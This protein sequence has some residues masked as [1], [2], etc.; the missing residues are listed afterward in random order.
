MAPPRDIHETPHE[1]PPLCQ[2]DHPLAAAIN[3]L[4]RKLNRALREL[5]GDGTE[6]RPGVR[7]RL[8]R[9]ERALEPDVG[10]RIDRLEQSAATRKVWGTGLGL[11]LA[12][13]LFER[14]LAW[15]SGHK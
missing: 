8:D 7:I 5:E 12:A 4:D 3:V 14:A 2:S 13:V 9:V 1:E 11:G 10:V 6:H 15:V